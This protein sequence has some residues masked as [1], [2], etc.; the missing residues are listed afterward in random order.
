M[1][2]A[3][4]VIVVGILLWLL[5]GALL[6]PYWFYKLI[7]ER[8]FLEPSHWWWGITYDAENFGLPILCL[9]VALWV[10]LTLSRTSVPDWM[11]ARTK[12]FWN[13]YVVGTRFWLTAVVL[14]MISI[15]VVL[16]LYQSSSGDR[17]AIQQSNEITAQLAESQARLQKSIDAMKP[18]EEKP[19]L[20][21]PTTF[22][23][24]D[25]AVVDSLYG[26]YSPELIPALVTEELKKSTEIQAGANLEGY[27]STEAG[28]QEFNSR[29]T[30]FKQT[31]KNSERKLEELFRYLNQNSQLKSFTNTRPTSADLKAL[32]DATQLLS[33]KY[34]LIVDK[35]KLTALRDRL[36]SNEKESLD[37][38]LRT[39]HGLVLVQGDWLVE[40]RQDAF[41]LRRP[42]MED[43]TNAP[44]CEV[45]LKRD[46]VA[47]RNREI[48][49]R[50]GR[51]RMR[52]S[53]F[54]NVLVGTS[55][56]SNTV[57][58]SPIAVF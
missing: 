2:K 11:L 24:L 23:F 31:D 38:Q 51:N 28:R 17:A 43:V 39:L 20:S 53:V 54:G 49:E 21:Q 57:L 14:V 25:K 45:T 56:Q 22:V 1:P 12:S 44:V 16:L 5:I 34:D 9:V 32:D 8:G 41:V 27:L 58:L 7:Y 48:L 37:T 52:L 46:G 50:M 55:S 36:L 33:H 10:L 18:D 13:S 30:Q 42:F 26:Q 40:S 19:P 47:E 6:Y 15:P 35:R 29:I 4:K 3:I